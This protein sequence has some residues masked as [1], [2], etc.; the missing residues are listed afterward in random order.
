MG[1]CGLI[2]MSPLDDWLAS[3][4]SVSWERWELFQSEYIDECGLNRS[5]VNMY[6]PQH[7]AMEGPYSNWV[8]LLPDDVVSRLRTTADFD[9]EFREI[10]EETYATMESSVDGDLKALVDVADMS[11]DVPDIDSQSGQLAYLCSR[12]IPPLR[13]D[14]QVDLLRQGRTEVPAEPAIEPPEATAEITVERR[15]E[16][17]ML[18]VAIFSIDDPVDFF[19]RRYGDS[20][21]MLEQIMNKGIA[22]EQIIFNEAFESE[23]S[24]WVK[25]DPPEHSIAIRSTDHKNRAQ[26]FKISNPREYYG[27]AWGDIREMVI[28]IGNSDDGLEKRDFIYDTGVIDWRIAIGI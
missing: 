7:P 4:G 10:I 11:Q 12:L 21:L 13:G 20:T 15:N 1:R 2:Y 14:V 5:E 28:E 6:V 3:A 8:R 26:F 17:N 16:H 24:S 27:D 25:S 18:D 9:T 19:G 23:G 22:P